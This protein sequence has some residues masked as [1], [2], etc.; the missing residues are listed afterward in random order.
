M[1]PT[2]VGLAGPW[3]SGVRRKGDR[4]AT[5]PLTFAN[6]AS[7]AGTSATCRRYPN[8]ARSCHLRH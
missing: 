3:S 7:S 6:Y 2:L 5:H 8:A 4:P 1:G